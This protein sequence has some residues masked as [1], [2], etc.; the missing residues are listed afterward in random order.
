LSGIDS[1]Q[2][3]L[4]APLA[5]RYTLSLRDCRKLRIFTLSHF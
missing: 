3:H 2:E 1:R 5:N 4:A